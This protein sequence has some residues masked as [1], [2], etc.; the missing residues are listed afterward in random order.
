M[1]TA[2]A[3]P[4]GARLPRLRVDV[5]GAWH[6]DDVEVTHPGILANLR[7]NLR[8]DAGGYFIQT[9]VRIPVE[10]ADVPWV[11]VRLERR[12]ERLHAVLNDATEEDVDAA[13]L[14]VGP[15]D[16]PYC[17]VKGGAFEARFSRAAAFQLL[18]LAEYDERT[19]RG[20]LRLGGREYPLARAS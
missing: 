20:A 10:V 2:G 4:G 17:A 19:G 15:G 7:G 8:Q 5:D 6:D 16:V 18:A 11:V 14:R 12:G 9:R 13:T 3:G 1:E